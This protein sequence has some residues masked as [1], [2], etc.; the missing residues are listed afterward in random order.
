M[1]P[2]LKYLTTI[3]FGKLIFQKDILAIVARAG[4]LVK[5]NRPIPGSV[6]NRWQT[7]RLLVVEP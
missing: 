1:K 5:E 2:A 3:D 4:M 7:A 6:D